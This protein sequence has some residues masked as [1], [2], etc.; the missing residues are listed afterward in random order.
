MKRAPSLI[1]A[2]LVLKCCLVSISVSLLC[3]STF[4]SQALLT[5]HAHAC[6]DTQTQTET[7]TLGFPLRQRLLL[8]PYFSWLLSL[9]FCDIFSKSLETKLFMFLLSS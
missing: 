2:R 5:C 1:L 6:T 4:L 8:G 7:E 3:F 9:S